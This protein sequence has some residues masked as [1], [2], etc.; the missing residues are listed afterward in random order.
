MPYLVASLV[1]CVGARV[2]LTDNLWVEGGL[3][4]GAVGVMKDI[5][6][7]ADGDGNR[8]QLPSFVLVE[9]PGYIGASYVNR[10][11]VEMPGCVPIVPVTHNFQSRDGVTDYSN[12]RQQ[13]PLRLAWAISIHKSQG[14]TLDRVVINL[15]DREDSVGLSYVAFSRARKLDRMWFFKFDFSRLANLSKSKALLLRLGEENRLKA[16]FENGKGH[17]EGLL[18]IYRDRF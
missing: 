4:N 16:M 11:G 13:L 12:S 10:Q 15:G 3:C 17:L 1:L 6:F 7:E 5:V 14:L 8:N 18:R 9:F 2:M